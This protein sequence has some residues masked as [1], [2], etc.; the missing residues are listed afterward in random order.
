RPFPW[1]TDTSFQLLASLEGALLTG[2]IVSRLGS[3]RASLTRARSTPYLLYCW[4]LTA[5]YAITFSSFA[6][7]GLLVRQRSLVLPA[8]FVLLCVRAMPR[9]APAGDNTR[10][11]S[12][13]P[14]R[15]GRGHDHVQRGAPEAVAGGLRASR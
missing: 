12:H 9:A 3:V 8:L 11:S 4:A 14:P 6:N 10:R 1:E 15:N 5:L 7:F 2:F 13:F